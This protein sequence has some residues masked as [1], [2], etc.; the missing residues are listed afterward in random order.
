GEPEAFDA[1]LA[2]LRIDCIIASN[3]GDLA[4][5]LYVLVHQMKPM[6]RCEC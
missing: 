3:E 4:N 5:L 6:F 1:H 2:Q